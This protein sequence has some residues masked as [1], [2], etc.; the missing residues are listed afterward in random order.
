VL[1]SWRIYI[2]L[3][4]VGG[5]EGWV[6]QVRRIAKNSFG[7]VGPATRRRRVGKDEDFS[8]RMVVFS[9]MSSTRELP[10]GGVMWIRP[11]ATSLAKDVSRSARRREQ[12]S[13]SARRSSIL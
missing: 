6:S 1:A 13:S 12:P 2:I 11:E 7:A 3:L 9:A 10:V 4:R 5:G 8:L